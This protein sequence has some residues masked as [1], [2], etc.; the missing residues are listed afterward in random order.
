MSCVR[1][2][3]IVALASGVLACDTTPMFQQPPP[4]D[5]SPDAT[6]S[7]TTPD[8]GSAADASAPDAVVHCMPA[9][10]AEGQLQCSGSQIQV[11]A[12]TQG[13][14]GWQTMMTCGASE[15]CRDAQCLPTMCT[16][17]AITPC[18]DRGVCRGGQ[19]T[20]VSGVWSTCNWQIG[21]SMEV[22]D[23][24][25]N[26][27]DGAV[28]DHLMLTLCPKQQGVCAGTLQ[29]C[30]PAQGG[31]VCD[32]TAYTD[33]AMMN[34]QT[35]QEMET[36]C[37]GQDN[38]CDGMVDNTAVCA[39]GQHCDSA[40]KAC[41]CD[42]THHA[43]G[44]QCLS[45][46]SVDSC[47]GSCT[48]CP[49]DPHGQPGCSAN[50]CTISCSGGFH[51]CGSSC[52]D[53]TSPATCGTSCSPCPQQDPHGQATCTN[54][55][56]GTQCSN[57]YRMCG[58]PVCAACPTAGVAQTACLGPICVAM[59]CMPGLS[60]CS[61]GCCG[62]ST[63]LVATSASLEQ[64]A[65][66]IDAS[67]QT[68]IAYIWS[69]LQ[70]A[71]RIA[72]GS[73]TPQGVDSEA[74][75]HVAMTYNGGELHLAY[76][77][78]N[79]GT[80]TFSVRHAHGTPLI[81]QDLDDPGC[82]SAGTWIAVNSS[83]AAYV[84]FNYD[85]QNTGGD[86]RE[87]NNTTGVFSGSLVDSQYAGSQ[88]QAGVAFDSQGVAIVDS[89]M[90]G[91]IQLLRFTGTSWAPTTI[92]SAARS[93]VTIQSGPSGLIVAYAPVAGGVH[94]ARQNGTSWTT[95]DVNTM[96]QSSDHLSLAIDPMS[97][98]PHLV[99]VSGG[100]LIYASSVQGTWTEVTVDTGVS[101]GALAIDA[102]GSAHIAYVKSTGTL[103]YAH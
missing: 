51:E 76:Q 33:Q 8:A 10:C 2:L 61:T 87:Q 37:D 54:G 60:P 36:L 13:C 63:E 4:E 71:T 56:C 44:S 69:G 64:P 86:I 6:T 46:D 48:P 35:Y 49:T 43:C 40:L 32:A 94:V 19:R 39:P 96:A 1:T 84:L 72:P 66:A 101:Y 27:C 68:Y 25:D 3:A 58:G 20:C 67:G 9:M 55:S 23:G 26:D 79:S 81:P 31:L 77:T 28:D 82:C 85:A 47:G 24:L 78:F 88:S 93:D 65:I 34:G 14:L 90:G 98:E 50:M 42:S 62:F 103:M 59:Q 57:G 45:N 41:A 11:C 100:S 29:R 52:A 38:D 74:N 21:P 99:Y 75:R 15:Q 97:G 83:N 95:E 5:H 22:C 53:N 89:T 7:T 73:W 12:R 70:L 102:Q 17:G 92:T 80:N 16:Q 91:T 18:P 30:A